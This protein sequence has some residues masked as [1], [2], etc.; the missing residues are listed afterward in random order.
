[1]HGRLLPQRCSLLHEMLPQP[2][3][4][5]L[6][7][8]YLA[9]SKKQ[10]NPPAWANLSRCWRRLGHAFQDAWCGFAL[11]VSQLSTTPLRTECMVLEA[12]ILNT[13]ER[14]TWVSAV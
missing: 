7:F 4:T 3:R 8:N 2:R 10:T 9:A 13:L 1:M 11:R 5:Q 12:S 14:A 6:H